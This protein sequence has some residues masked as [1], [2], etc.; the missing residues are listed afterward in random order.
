MPI[1]NIELTNTY[2]EWRIITNSI[3]SQLNSLGEAS[4]ITIS[5]GSI[6]GTTIGVSN[7][8]TGV[9]T[10]LTVSTSL[11]LSGAALILDNDSIS[12]DK[13]SGGTIDNATVQ[14]AAAPTSDSHA[15]RKDYVDSEITDLKDELINIAMLFGD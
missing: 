13:I 2:N 1:S 3:I 15:T 6:D 7:P 8:S 10:S 12:G 5:G 14:I 9:F 11:T 4:D